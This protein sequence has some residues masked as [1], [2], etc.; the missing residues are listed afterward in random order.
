MN[1]ASHTSNRSYRAYLHCSM[2]QVYM[3]QHLCSQL[4]LSEATKKVVSSSYQIY[5]IKRL[6]FNFLLQEVKLTCLYN[7]YRCC[8]KYCF[9]MKGV[10]HS[11]S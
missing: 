6:Y 8:T 3:F 5:D 9:L 7:I 1:R 4:M 10:S 2:V 11:N